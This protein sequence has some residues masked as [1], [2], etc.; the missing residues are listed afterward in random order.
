MERIMDKQ[1][2]EQKPVTAQTTVTVD[3]VIMRFIENRPHVL[4]VLRDRPPY[5]WQ[6][7]LPGGKLAEQDATL[8]AAAARE[9]QE[10]TGLILPHVLKP[11]MLGA[12]GDA[13]RDPR[14]GRWISIAFYA[15]LISALRWEQIMERC[16]LRAG[17]DACEVKWFPVWNLPDLAFDHHAIIECASAPGFLHIDRSFH[18]TGGWS[19]HQRG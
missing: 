9:L 6:W 2:G 12:F 16:A 5:R 17:D 1:S 10:E 15:P 8:E 11:R 18:S 3:M 7:A 19:C 14:P 13:G 4:L